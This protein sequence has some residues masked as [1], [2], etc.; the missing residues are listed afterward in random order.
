VFCAKT[1]SVKRGSA[2]IRDLSGTYSYLHYSPPPLKFI[3]AGHC[4]RLLTPFL[5]ISF[6]GANRHGIQAQQKNKHNGEHRTGQQNHKLF[7]F[8]SNNH[9]LRTTL[10]T[11]TRT[12]RSLLHAALPCLLCLT[13]RAGPLPGHIWC[14]GHGAFCCV[15][16]LPLHVIYA[17]GKGLAL[18]AAL[19]GYHYVS[20]LV[21]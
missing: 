3:M 11:C 14:H 5:N 16:C 19:P 21:L 2:S 9:T 6:G 4:V 13:L 18:V 10:C 1:P 17:S 7:I 8:N 15:T 20:A 12:F